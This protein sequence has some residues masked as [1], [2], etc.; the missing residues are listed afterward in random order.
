MARKVTKAP[1]F[2]RA[3]AGLRSWHEAIMEGTATPEQAA[4]RFAT[5]PMFRRQVGTLNRM[6]AP[7]VP[8]TPQLSAQY[9]GAVPTPS[10]MAAEKQ[11]VAESGL[12]T[13]GAEA[14]LPFVKRRAELGVQAIEDPLAQQ[15]AAAQ[16]E[17]EMHAPALESAGIANQITQ[18]QLAEQKATAPYRERDIREGPP[19]GPRDYLQAAPPEIS[20]A[21]AT[22]KLS[23]EMGGAV[24]NFQ[25]QQAINKADTVMAATQLDSLLGEGVVLENGTVGYSPKEDLLAKKDV[26][27]PSRDTVENVRAVLSATQ[28]A[29]AQASPDVASIIKGRVRR[30]LAKTIARWKKP[31][32][33]KR[34][35]ALP[36]LSLSKTYKELMPLIE[37]LEGLVR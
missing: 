26:G 19:I 12:A 37:E 6:G 23:P 16:R 36:S 35:W 7:E 24:A 4:A 33:G 10:G 11:A 17:Q 34:I 13:G 2:M 8:T 31:S 3:G 25:K 15:R 21:I 29:L 14:E 30:R 27:A 32:I 20:G 28:D 22:Q 18:Q 9:W 5:A 1:A